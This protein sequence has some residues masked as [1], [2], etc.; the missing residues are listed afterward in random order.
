MELT[1]LDTVCLQLRP[2]PFLY[3]FQR[4]GSIICVKVF[5]N[6]PSKICRREPLKNLNRT[7]QLYKTHDLP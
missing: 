5:K 1:P 4:S 3:I 7:S 6:G 2:K